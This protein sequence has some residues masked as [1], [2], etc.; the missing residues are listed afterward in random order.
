M[1][2]DCTGKFDYKQ[3]LGQYNM[4]MV[5]S[6]SK[7]RRNLQIVLIVLGIGLALKMS[8]N[9][10]RVYWSGQRLVQAQK[11]LDLAQVEQDGLK[12]TLS[13]VRT[14]EFVEKEAREKLGYGREGEV[15]LIMPK[16][17]DRTKGEVLSAKN[18]PAWKQWWKLY[19]GLP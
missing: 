8:V 6:Q 1:P 9:I 19:I 5:A 3:W 15:V 7:S 12:K 13:Y 18:L 16:F 17:P 10:W 2:V 4:D 14:P 11:A